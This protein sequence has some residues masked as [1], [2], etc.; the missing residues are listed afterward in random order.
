MRSPIS[1]LIPHFTLRSIKSPKTLSSKPELPNDLNSE[2]PLSQNPNPNT[3]FPGKSAPTSQNSTETHVINTL[4]NHKNDPQ[5]AE[6]PSNPISESS[7]SQLLNPNTNF[8]ENITDIP[9]KTAPTSQDSVLTQTQCINTL[10]SHQNDPQ[11]AFSYFTWASKKRG[12]IRSVD[13]LCV[14]LHILAKSTETCGKARDLLN[15]FASDD[16]GPVPSVVV[17]RLIES[18]RRLDFE[19][20]SRVFNYLLN[21]YVKTKRINDAIDCFNSLIEKDI[22]PCLTVMNIFLS[23]LVKNNMICQARDVYNK[24]VSKGVRGDCA[25][26]S[27]MIRASMREGKLEEAEGWFREA[28]NKGIELDARAYSIAVEAVCKK[29]DSVAACGLLREMRDKGWVPHE[30]IFTRVIGVCMKQGKMLEAVKVKG[31]M[32]SCGK[33]TN[34]VVA[35]T[36]MKGYCKQGD[37]DSAL[38]LFDKMNENGICP[39]NVT[40]AVI[41]EW[42]CKNGNMDRAYEIYNQ[43]KNNDISPTVFNLNSLIRGY[44]KAQSPEEASKL[45]DEAVACGIANVFTYNSLLS[46]LCKEGKMSEACSIW[47][48][49]VRKGVQPSVVSYNNMIFGHCQQGDLDSANG[50]FVEMDEKGLKP[51]LITYSVLMDGYFKKGDTEYAFSLYDRMRGENIVPSDFTCNIIIHGLC[52]AGRTSESQDRLKKLVQEGFIPTCRTYNCIIDGFVKEGSVN[53]ALAVYTEM[54]KIGVSPNVFTYT[55]LINGFCKSNNVD[56]ALK[57]M[58]EMKNKGIEMDVTVYSALIDGFCRKGDMVNAS[59]LL[60]ELQEVGLSPNRVVYSSMI[61]GFRKLQNM[62]SALHLHKRM[63]NEGIPCDLQIYT[64]LISGLL[65]EGKLLFASELYAEM[66][67][68]GIMPDLI[69]YSV[70]IHGLCNEGHVENAQ[71]ILEDMDKKCMTPSVFIYNTLIT[72]HFKEGNLQEAFRL[73]NEMLDKGLVPD[74]TTYDILV[75]GKD[76]LLL[77]VA[78]KFLQLVLSLI[79]SRAFAGISCYSV[80][81]PI[82]QIRGLSAAKSSVGKCAWGCAC[83][84]VKGRKDFPRRLHTRAGLV[85]LKVV[86]DCRARRTEAQLGLV[87]RLQCIGE[88]QDIMKFKKGS[89]V[90]VLRKTDFS[91]GAWWCGEIISGNRQTYQVRYDGSQCWSNVDNV[92]SVSR[93][94][95]R[96]CPLPADVSDDWTVGDLVEVFDDL[97]WKTA[98]VLKVIGGNHYLVR[99]I[100]PS[101]ELQVNKVNIRMRR[102]WL[103]GKWVVIGKGSGSFENEKSNKRSVWSFYQKMRSPRQQASKKRKVQARETCLAIENTAGF[104]ESRAMSAR[105]SKGAPPFWSSNC[106]AYNGKVDTMRALEKQNEGQQV[107]SGYPSSFLKKVDAVACPR[108]CL[109]ETYMHA[110]SNNQTIGSCEMKRGTPNYAVDF[111]GRSLEPNGSDSDACSVGSCSVTSDS[112]NRLFNHV[113]AGNNPDAD[114]LSSDAKSFYGHGD[115]EENCSIPLGEDVTARV[116]SFKVVNDESLH[117]SGPKSEACKFC[118]RRSKDEDAGDLWGSPSFSGSF[119]FVHKWPDTDIIAISSLMLYSISGV[120][121]SCAEYW[122]K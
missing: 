61:N 80:L 55:N 70:L 69:T 111:C 58:D 48:K 24:M 109:G 113:L 81:D 79:F 36:L 1:S 2:T 90:E 82:L 4:P 22:V 15:R 11:S 21:S 9:G 102:L 117:F 44:L 115:E 98:A 107:I 93:K 47:E 120:P 57:V 112:P 104:Q 75:N 108:E 60:S 87:A 39:N 27:V 78:R 76:P 71:K 19:S 56:L 74:D 95:I 8:P 100:G 99:L 85:S 17:A 66:L 89:R 40:Y 72:G 97:C 29:P 50:V 88:L 110:S 34:V 73:H 84:R 33:P 68:K 23:A 37:L 51:N 54:C 121:G 119:Q 53:S 3:S 101:T 62:E 45:F 59:Q 94:A 122:M 77:T 26:I 64:S 41:I 103:D 12:L 86:N 42:C 46:W 14:L 106:E 43:M 52:K 49:M 16:W 92:E 105:T 32:L 83:L 10:L 114:T 35:T 7:P 6:S 65:K 28:K 38:E 5:L 67:A 18:S 91:S 118:F 30:V 13:A 20:D 116:R 63:I 31:E 25:T 96:P